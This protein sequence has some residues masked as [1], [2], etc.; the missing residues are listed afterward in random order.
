MLQRATVWHALAGVVAALVAATLVLV[1]QPLGIAALALA[2]WI[3]IGAALGYLLAAVTGSVRAGAVALVVTQLGALGWALALV[4]PEVALLLLLAPAVWLALRVGGRAAAVV[5]GVG[6]LAIYAGWTGVT[7]ARLLIPLLRLS[8]AGSRWLEIALAVLAVGLTLGAAVAAADDRDRSEAAARARLY[9][10][11]LLRAELAA[12]RTQTEKD[13]LHVQDALL[14][15]VRGRGQEPISAEGALSPAA[16]AVNVV[17][18]RLATLQKDREDRLRL[19]GALR[20]LIR[21]LERGWL[22][23]PWDWP[24]PSGTLLDQLVTLLQLPQPSN[25]LAPERWLADV[26]TPE[27]LP[28]AGVLGRTPAFPTFPADPRA[29]SSPWVDWGDPRDR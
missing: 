18:E 16:E 25:D 28:A 13:S 11:R 20:A 8:I 19:E 29:A 17:A 4:G 1:G 9:E 14:R 7:A 12:L 5:C 15:A 23:L 10:L 3:T 21:T 27:D 2:G 24:E 26:P 22:G 6:G